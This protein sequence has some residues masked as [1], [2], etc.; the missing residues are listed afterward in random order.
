MLG[1]P[2]GSQP[3]PR[4]MAGVKLFV[5]SIPAESAD[6][7][8]IDEL[9]RTIDAETIEVAVLPPKGTNPT[10]RCAFV[11]VEQSVADRVCS[12]LNGVML[13]GHP[14]PLV[15]RIADNQGAQPQPVHP[16]PAGTALPIN[17]PPAP[18][19]MR[20]RPASMG[21]PAVA[22]AHYAVASATSSN[23]SV[24]S[25]RAPM[26]VPP[27]PAQPAHPPPGTVASA[28]IMKLRAKAEGQWRKVAEWQESEYAQAGETVADRV[29][30]LCG[31]LH[32]AVGCQHYYEAASLADM[33]HLLDPARAAD[34]NAQAVAALAAAPEDSEQ[35]LPLP[36]PPLLE[37]HQN[38]VSEQ[39]YE[40]TIVT[41]H[42]DR[43]YGFIQSA[44]LG[45][46]AFV[47]DKQICSFQVGDRVFFQVAF[48]AKGQPQAQNLAYVSAV[49]G[50]HETAEVDAQHE[51][52]LRRP[53]NP[54]P[55]P[56][57]IPPKR[58]RLE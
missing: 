32:D 53:I 47:S 50:Q 18:V 54:P 26:V 25:S 5:G 19:G 17:P 23:G 16:R 42:R 57:V 49:E 8:H 3:F 22:H 38:P 34:A 2:G 12:E 52:R 36:A 29:E 28:S 45:Q 41:F 11:R 10:T 7:D 31:A 48:N 21:S 24:A 37:P 9:F 14:A 46:D 30:R 1:S 51:P 35:G 58:P 6:Q 27:A 39:V 20:N 33:L 4:R 40:G 55:A 43:R 15:V 56:V 44:E 13:E